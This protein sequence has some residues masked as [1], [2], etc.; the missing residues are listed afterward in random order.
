V[1][2]GGSGAAASEGDGGS[3]RFE[4]SGTDWFE[5]SFDFET[6]DGSTLS[7][8]DIQRAINKGDSYVERDDGT[9]ILFDRDA[10]ESMTGVFHD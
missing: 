7:A 9:K 2:E 3:Q 8:I 5:I 10:V 4:S 1:R 6:S